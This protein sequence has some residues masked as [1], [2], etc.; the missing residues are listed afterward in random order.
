MLS[1]AMLTQ[2]TDN[3]SLVPLPMT[4]DV[5]LDILVRPTTLLQCM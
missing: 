1:V 4:A 2:F 3:P 5:Y